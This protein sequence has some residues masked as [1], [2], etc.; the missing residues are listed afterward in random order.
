MV[1]WGGGGQCRGEGIRIGT[2]DRSGRGRGELSIG[3]SGNSGPGFGVRAVGE[4]Q[5]LAATDAYRVSGRLS[6]YQY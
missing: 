6:I 2:S 5:A 3:L 4:L 1:V